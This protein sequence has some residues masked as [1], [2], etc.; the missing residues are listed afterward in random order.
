VF[1]HEHVEHV[2]RGEEVEDIAISSYQ[3]ELHVAMQNE[4]VEQ[5]L[6]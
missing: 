4:E 1:E 6:R 5:V 3:T 2:N